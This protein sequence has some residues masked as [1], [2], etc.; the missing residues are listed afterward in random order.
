MGRGALLGPEGSGR[1]LADSGL[2][3]SGRFSTDLSV[4]C[5]AGANLHQTVGSVSCS[6]CFVSLVRVSGRQVM[7]WVGVPARILRTV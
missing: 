1:I 6:G 5:V 4:G 3:S 2:V 7:V